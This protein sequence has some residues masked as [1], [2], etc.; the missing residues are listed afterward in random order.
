MAFVIFTASEP[1]RR[2]RKAEG[3][4]GSRLGAGQPA[5]QVAGDARGGRHRQPRRLHR[6]IGGRRCHSSA[7]ISG[8]VK[9]LLAQEEKRTA[10]L[11]ED[12]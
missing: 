10:R 3:Q 2:F 9:P 4:T 1:S 5:G 11:V 12:V 7:R 6:V 8:R